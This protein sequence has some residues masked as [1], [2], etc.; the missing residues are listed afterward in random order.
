MNKKSILKRTLLSSAILSISMQVAASDNPGMVEALSGF[1]T[2]EAS[3]M[4]KTGITVGLWA[5]AGVSGN[6]NGK[7]NEPISFNDKV[8]EF[9][10]NQLNFFIERAVNTE[11][12][13]WDIGGRMDF[14]YGTDA[15]FTQASGW[16]GNWNKHNNG[17]YYDI[18]MPQ[19]YVEIFAPIG[20]GITAKLG[21][22]YTTIGNEVVTSPD[23]F[24]YSHAYTMLYGEPFTH[25][26]AL[27]SYDINDNFSINGGAVIGWDNMTEN[28]GAWSF[29]GGGSWTSDS[30]AT[31]VTVQLISGN[32]SDTESG[33]TTMYSIVATHDFTDNF[34]YLLQHDFGTQKYA[35]GDSDNWFGINQ[36]FTYDLTDKL[37]VGL[38]AEWFNDKANA[39]VSVKGAN[40]LAASVG[41]NY[42]V[43][44]WFKVRP[45][46]R[47][48][49]ADEDVFNG[50][51]DHDQI[52][53]AMDMIVT[54]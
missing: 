19:L 2:N 3:F 44:S 11:G 26:G 49:W 36:Y 16:D 24:F 14:M 43:V 12:N 39:R 23:N 51:A 1:S 15:R 41:V 13:G 47:Y 42:S 40:Y 35:N 50:G 17:G 6:S 30:Q 10:L 29:L 38:R 21:H 20:N 9:N 45:E 4:Q 52:A 5:S 28:A 37:S 54:F 53:I 32:Q 31:S 27:F 34:H 18:A 48:D 33:N 25:T 7:T 46:V 8:N 22:F